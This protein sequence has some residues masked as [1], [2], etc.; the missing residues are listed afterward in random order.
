MYSIDI[1]KKAMKFLNYRLV[2]DIIISGRK[3]IVI[4]IGHRRNVYEQLG[5]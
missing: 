4:A 1:A 3:I 5:L 2:M